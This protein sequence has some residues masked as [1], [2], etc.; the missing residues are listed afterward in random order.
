MLQTSEFTIFDVLFDAVVVLNSVGEILY[1]NKSFSLLLNTSQRRIKRGE[2]LADYVEFDLPLYPDDSISNITE[3]TAYREVRFIAATGKSGTVQ[4]AI[5]PLPRPSAVAAWALYI[6]DVDLEKE[7]HR[8]YLIELEQKDALNEILHTIVAAR[9]QAFV[10]VNPA[11]RCTL[12]SHRFGDIFGISPGEKPLQEVLRVSELEKNDFQK[13]WTSLF[14]QGHKT[15]QAF[16]LAH[17]LDF[18]VEFF[19]I[20]QDKRVKGI[21]V[22][23]S[24]RGAKVTPLKK[25]S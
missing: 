24:D 3:G 21:V 2:A 9:G 5:Q 12:F 8:K 10:L 23:G 11:G 22:V 20:V 17:N 13:W 6:R 16:P 14:D 18:N 1:A 25:S 19:P 15:P 7:L 4:V